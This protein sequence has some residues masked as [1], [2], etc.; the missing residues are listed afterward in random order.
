MYKLI[1]SVSLLCLALLSIIAWKVG[2]FNIFITSF[3]GIDIEAVINNTYVSGILSGILSVII[4]YKWQVWYSKRKLKEDF[5]CN[6]CIN[7]IFMSIEEFRKYEGNI[8]KEIHGPY[9]DDKVDM[10]DPEKAESYRNIRSQNAL[11][12][13][14]FYEKYKVQIDSV[15][16][17]LSYEGLNLL[18]ESIQTC[19]FINLNFTLL[20]II[21]NVKNRLL[22]LRKQYPVI[23][24]LDEKYRITGNQENSIQLGEMLSIYFVDLKFMVKYWKELLDYLGYDYEYESNFIHLYRQNYNVHDFL[25]MPVDEQLKQIR[26]ISKDAKKMTWRNKFKNHWH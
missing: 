22:S 13:V 3:W 23:K 16:Q 5:R 14:K 25:E 8:P 15:T 4:I 19:F 6:E 7:D 12:Y 2:A 21:N 1:F 9:F 17:G 18:L 26:K 11:R 10:D 24:S 20:M